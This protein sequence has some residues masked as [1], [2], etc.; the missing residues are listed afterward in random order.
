MNTR[1]CILVK[2]YRRTFYPS[3]P[4][5][6]T[7][8]PS[9]AVP[10]PLVRYH[11]PPSISPSCSGMLVARCLFDQVTGDEKMWN[12]KRL[13]AHQTKGEGNLKS[14]AQIE[15]WT[16]F[17]KFHFNFRLIFLKSLIFY[18]RSWRVT[19]SSKHPVA[20]NRPKQEPH[21]WW[22]A[23]SNKNQRT[24]R[25]WGPNPKEK[26]GGP[27]RD[28][29]LNIIA[30][31]VYEVDGIFVKI[32]QAN[33]VISC[34]CL[35]PQLRTPQAGRYTQAR[36]TEIVGGYN[37]SSRQAVMVKY[38]QH[39]VSTRNSTGICSTDRCDEAPWTSTPTNTTGSAVGARIPDQQR[40]HG[41]FC[42]NEKG[43]GFSR[44]RKTTPFLIGA[45]PA[46]ST[47]LVVAMR[48]PEAKTNLL[49]CWCS[50]GRLDRA[51]HGHGRARV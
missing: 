30:A 37:V 7:S 43:C 3:P 31:R 51:G 44:N 39:T 14:K 10:P 4:L 47:V 1:C 19:Y 15:H 24:G 29:R 20:I 8:V 40:R 49:S 34:R 13:R 12:V 46:V 21:R 11:R 42:L 41:L 22:P 50:T 23:A 17:L 9:L 33:V 2:I 5:L 32:T 28:L 48:A 16:M 38:E 18:I 45:V 36:N 25:R 27:A 6:L 35:L 26:G